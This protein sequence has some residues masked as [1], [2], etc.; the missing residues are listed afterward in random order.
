MTNRTDDQ[1]RAD[2]EAR[3]FELINMYADELNAEALDVLR[4]QTPIDFEDDLSEHP[5]K[6]TADGRKRLNNL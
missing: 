2:R 6:K 1:V 4:Y 5:I 3:D